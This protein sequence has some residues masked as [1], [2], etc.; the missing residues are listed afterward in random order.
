[1]YAPAPSPQY[2][3]ATAKELLP[4]FRSITGTTPQEHVGLRDTISFCD[5]AHHTQV[6]YS[7]PVLSNI[8]PHIDRLETL[9]TLMKKYQLIS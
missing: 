9:I 6:G 2:D 5:P 4:L 7:V 8:Q 1:M 3:L